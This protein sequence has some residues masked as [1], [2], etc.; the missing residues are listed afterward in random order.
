[1]AKAGSTSA[2]VTRWK[3]Q[4]QAANQGYS[5]LSGIAMTVGGVEMDPVAVAARLAA[6]VGGVGSVGS[7]SSH[8][9][10]V[11]VDRYCF[12]HSMPAKACRC[13]RR[14]VVVR[15]VALQV[16]VIGIRLGDA[17]LEDLHRNRRR[18]SGWRRPATSRTRIDDAAARR[19]RRARRCRPP[20]CPSR[21]VHRARV[22]VHDV[23]VEGVLEVAAPVG[24]PNSSRALVSLSQNSRS[25]G[26][27]KCSVKSPS[28]SCST[29]IALRRPPPSATASSRPRTRSRCCGTRPAAA[30]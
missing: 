6:R 15:D 8:S 4:S 2:S 11:V 26:C 30:R 13:T 24:A 20:W 16:G 25:C 22:A 17:R 9:A 3:A 28:V 27:S 5:H 29:L 1:M 12:D 23:L 19:T 10:D 14:D 7:P 21:R 18:R